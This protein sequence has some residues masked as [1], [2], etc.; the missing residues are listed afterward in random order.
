M[1]SLVKSLIIVQCQPL[2][3]S[4]VVFM[5]NTLNKIFSLLP[6]PSINSKRNSRLLYTGRMT[7]ESLTEM[8]IKYNLIVT[9]NFKCQN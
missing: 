3:G 4:Y 8:Q 5:Y 6:L 2:S 7:T 1:L 9:Y